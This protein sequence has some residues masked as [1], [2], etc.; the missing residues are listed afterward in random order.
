MSEPLLNFTLQNTSPMILYGPGASYAPLPSGPG[1]SNPSGWMVVK[2]GDSF[3]YYTTHE[4]SWLQ[5]QFYGTAIYLYG[6]TSIPFQVAVDSETDP[7]TVSQEPG[8]IF[9][10]ESLPQGMHNVNLTVGATNSS[11]A[12]LTFDHAV[13]ANPYAIT[14]VPVPFTYDDDNVRNSGGW[15]QF[16]N[17]TAQ[18]SSE[19]AF[20]LLEFTGAAVAITGPIS[21]DGEVYNV[22][23]DSSEPVE[24]ST[25][26]L[27][28]PSAQLFY[29]DGLD[30]TVQHSIM[31]TNVGDTAVTFD[32][33]TVWQEGATPSSLPSAPFATSTAVSSTL[34]SSGSHS[35]IV[36]I[37]APIVAV[38]GVIILAAAIWACSRRRQRQRLFMLT[39]PFGLRF[40]RAFRKPRSPAMMSLTTL[41]SKSEHAAD[42]TITTTDVA[43]SQMAMDVKEAAVVGYGASSY[44][45][46]EAV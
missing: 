4:H 46:K 17:G 25:L 39:G 12:N 5:L 2:S 22:T 9:M 1:V 6:S 27:G 34:S 7:P 42:A 30:P 32:S 21:V 24:F 38:I 3:S 14:R 15:T 10:R 18:T 8:L 20:A 23:L 36:K 43:Q 29:Q 26:A 28:A 40:S 19:G 44:H 35:N 41:E 37:V 16:P 31:L 13:L 45:A 33:I 11:T